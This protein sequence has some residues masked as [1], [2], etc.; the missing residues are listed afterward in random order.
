[1]EA[2][3]LRDDG[4]HAEVNEPGELWLRSGSIALGYWNNEEANKETFIDGWLRTGDRF[5]VD[6]D[7][8]FYFQDRSKVSFIFSLEVCLLC[9]KSHSSFRT[10]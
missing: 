4:T 2:R 3:I 5:S 6:E 9:I 8:V 10:L 1:M 7:G